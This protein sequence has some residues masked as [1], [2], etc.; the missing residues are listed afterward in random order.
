MSVFTQSM[1][2]ERVTQS[3]HQEYSMNHAFHASRESE[4]A[5]VNGSDVEPS[6]CA[7]DVN[8]NCVNENDSLNSF[9]SS[10]LTVNVP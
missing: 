8:E 6:D 5:N 10:S 4:I 1:P 3:V 2:S 7:G 9:H